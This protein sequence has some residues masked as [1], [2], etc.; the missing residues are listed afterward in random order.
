MEKIEQLEE[1]EEYKKYKKQENKKYLL[2][3]FLL[4]ISISI[5]YAAL[6]STLRIRGTGTIDNVRCDVHFENITES[7]SKVDIIEPATIQGNTTDIEYQINLQTLGSYYEFETDIKNS[8]TID[9]KLATNPSL[10]GISAEQDVYTNYTVTYSDG[11]PI[12]VGDIIKAG[13]SRRITVRVEIEKD[14]TAN[15]LPKSAQTLNLGVDLD[16]VQAD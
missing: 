9:A 16:Y 2:L 7:S 1:N 8:G 15:Q 4:L 12:R 10:T 6:S 11:T 14:L 3:I 5:G 13:E